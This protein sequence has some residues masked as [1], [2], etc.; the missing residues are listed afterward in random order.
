M[1]NPGGGGNAV[2][3]QDIN[4]DA[5][6]RSRDLI[7]THADTFGGESRTWDGFDVKIDVRL[8]GLL[9]Q[10]G[11]STGTTGNDFCPVW[12]ALPETL[13]ARE[14]G[15]NT[16]AREFCQTRTN[17]LTQIKFLGSYTLPHDIQLAGT[18][19][20]KPGPARLAEVAFAEG[21]I[22]DALG[23]PLAGGGAVIA[24]VLEPGSNYGER[25]NQVDLRFTKI[26][27]LG[28]TARLRAMFDIFNV[29]NANAVTNENYA[30]GPNYLLPLAIM[31]GRLGKFS[32]QFDF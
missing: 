12:S 31:P 10:G 11:V 13:S 20:S 5:F 21:Q 3:L 28:G 8:E 1:S 18:L 26:L 25:F 16:V 14:E 22:I 2:T 4:P 32:F 9:L 6:G 29:F 15:S 19:Q 7:T 27:P 30:V 17:W 24:N 23:R